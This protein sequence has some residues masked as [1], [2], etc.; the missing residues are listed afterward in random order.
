MTEN[1]HILILVVFIAVL[2]KQ[3]PACAGTVSSSS[4]SFSGGI[5]IEMLKYQE[6]APDMKLTSRAH[7]LNTIV[8]ISAEKKVWKLLLGLHGTVPIPM[9]SDSEKWERRGVTIQ[10]N[11]LQYEWY[12]VTGWIG[13]AYRPWLVPYSGLKWS[14]IIQKRTRFIVDSDPIPGSATET[15][16]TYELPV[17]FS[18]AF[19]FR[20]RYTISYDA[21]YTLP[22]YSTV[23]NSVFSDVTF[24][25]V[26][27]HGF[28]AMLGIGYN[29]SKK[30]A[31]RCLCRWGQ[32][33]R[34]PSDTIDTE[35]GSVQYPR[36]K[37]TSLLFAI[38]GQWRF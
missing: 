24:R 18:G 22:V 27:P 30:S 17:G 2:L 20:N 11:R 35:S 19:Q 12:R 16:M 3:S 8:N 28:E 38:T 33:Y 1:R 4:F 9:G 23:R 37:T 25:H 7:T 26:N 34:G 31:V 10:S 21:C 6:S 14:D 29:V 36:N 5:G 32:F 15:V 13:Y